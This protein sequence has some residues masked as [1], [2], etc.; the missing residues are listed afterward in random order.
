M[1]VYV[2]LRNPKSKYE[3]LIYLSYYSSIDKRYF[4]RSLGLKV[5]TKNWKLNKS[6]FGVTLSEKKVILSKKK[7]LEDIILDLMFNNEPLTIANIK[8][9]FD[10]KSIELL[11][12]KNL[13]ELFLEEKCNILAKSSISA[14]KRLFNSLFE[15]EKKFDIRQYNENTQNSYINHLLKKDGLS[16]P[17]IVLKLKLLN[18]FIKWSNKKGYSNIKVIKSTIK[19][20]TSTKVYLTIEEIDRLY[21]LDDETLTPNQVKARDVFIF[22]CTTSLRI[23]DVKQVNKNNIREESIYINQQKTKTDVIIPLNIYSKSILIKYK[24]KL[25]NIDR[26]VLNKHIRFLCILANINDNVEIVEFFQGKK[27]I[28]NKPKSLLISSHTGRRSY[29]THLIK[30]GIAHQIIMKI[31]GHKTYDSFQKYVKLE[32]SDIVSA[33][34]D[35]F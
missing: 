14:Y 20:D 35:V 22:L 15:F 23:S 26:R 5:T 32:G 11:P 12:Q 8:R 13:F 18:V 30:R 7:Q 3:S 9:A 21:N 31:S 34:K 2:K 16:N 28:Y 17:S 29:I 1:N 19:V 33:V 6:D 25:P 27:K 10:N 4:K 24:Y